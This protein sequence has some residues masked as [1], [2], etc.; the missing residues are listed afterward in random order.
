M[1]GVGLGLVGGGGGVVG[2]GWVGVPQGGKNFD[3]HWSTFKVKATCKPVVT[4]TAKPRPIENK[5][6]NS[7]A[8][9]EITLRW[10]LKE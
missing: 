1:G 8:A 10:D 3:V 4:R 6:T 7:M 5:I 9:T 2:G